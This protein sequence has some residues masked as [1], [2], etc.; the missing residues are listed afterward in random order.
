MNSSLFGNTTTF[1]AAQRNS[2]TS[3][4]TIFA[5]WTVSYMRDACTT[6]GF[7]AFFAN[8]MVVSVFLAFRKTLAKQLTTVSSNFHITWQVFAMIKLKFN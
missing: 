3:N 4:I 6:I 2:S 5:T 7:I 8:F 1:V